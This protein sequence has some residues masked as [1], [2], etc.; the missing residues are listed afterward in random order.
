MR[1][2]CPKSCGSCESTKRRKVS[3]SAQ[4]TMTIGKPSK[5]KVIEETTNYGEQQ[6][7]AGAEAQLTLKLLEEMLEY[8]KNDSEFLK[9]PKTIQENCQNKHKNC[10]FWAVIG[11]VFSLKS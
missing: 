6:E 8:M 11:K 5:D 9:L 2:N 7:V 1:K 4:E 10:G 3:V